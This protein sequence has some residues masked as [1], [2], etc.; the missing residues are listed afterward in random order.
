MGTKMRRVYADVNGIYAFQ[1][2]D[3]TWIGNL[4][5]VFPAKL[6]FKAPGCKFNFCEI[7]VRQGEPSFPFFGWDGNFEAPTIT[8]SIGCDD[9]PRCGWHGHIIK[10]EMFP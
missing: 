9:A 8:P 2:G 3:F 6:L 1:V 7:N 10:G 5:G 4:A